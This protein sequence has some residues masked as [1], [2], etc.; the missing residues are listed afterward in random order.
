[1]NELVFEAN[2]ETVNEIID[3]IKK[4]DA[5]QIKDIN[6]QIDRAR[7]KSEQ[8]RLNQIAI[9]A[10]DVKLARLLGVIEN[11]FKADMITVEVPTDPQVYQSDTLIADSSLNWYLYGEK[12]LL[13]RINILESRTSDDPFTPELITLTNQKVKLESNIIDLDSSS[14][15]A[16]KLVKYA[17]A[18]QIPNIPIKSRNK[19]IV[20]ITFF[21]GLMSSIFL[22]L[23]MNL[24]KE[25]E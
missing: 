1:M 14:I 11:N 8:V 24:F 7:Y 3:K 5:Q 20:A 12:A 25:D 13:A 6:G 10:A 22:A 17:S 18:K 16:M 15:T 19:L 21:I 4:Q 2:N 23:L 9:L